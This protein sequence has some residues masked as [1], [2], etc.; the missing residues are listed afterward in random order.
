MLFLL[1]YKD[2]NPQNPHGMELDA[3]NL[4]YKIARRS[5]FRGGQAWKSKPCDYFYSWGSPS[6]YWHESGLST[7]RRTLR[8]ATILIALSFQIKHELVVFIFYLQNFSRVWTLVGFDVIFV[9]TISLMQEHYLEETFKMRNLLEEFNESRRYG[10]RNPTIL[11]VREHV[12]TGRCKST[13]LSS[14]NSELEILRWKLSITYD[15]M[16]F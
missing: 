9:D 13:S 16:A 2:W 8:G 4:L 5:N 3:G 14:I 12:F 1:F 11:G 15:Q 10:H 7:L 6:D